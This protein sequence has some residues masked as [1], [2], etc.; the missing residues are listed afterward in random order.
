MG[1]GDEHRVCRGK[2]GARLGQRV[3]AG[4][5]GVAGGAQLLF[6]ATQSGVPGKA[7]PGARVATREIPG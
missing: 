7:E 2:A 1:R 5:R 3:E 6:P 4:G